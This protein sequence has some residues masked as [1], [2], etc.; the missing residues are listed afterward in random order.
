MNERGQLVADY[1][2]R[3]EEIR[4]TLQTRADSERELPPIDAQIQEGASILEGIASH[5]H[6]RRSPGLTLA[7]RARSYTEQMYWV[8]MTQS[9]EALRMETS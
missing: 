1:V 7:R 4:R 3:A 5:V 9:R 2:T 8:L 6:A